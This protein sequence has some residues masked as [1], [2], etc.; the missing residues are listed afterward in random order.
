MGVVGLWNIIRLIAGS[1]KRAS[2]S[3]YC[4]A[5]ACVLGS[6]GAR[7]DGESDMG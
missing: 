1:R 4:A 7:A 6:S 2:A 3:V 5:T